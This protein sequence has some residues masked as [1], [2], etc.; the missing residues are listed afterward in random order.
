MDRLLARL[1]AFAPEAQF[2]LDYANVRSMLEQ[3]WPS[4]SRKD[5]LGFKRSGFGRKDLSSVFTTSNSLQLLKYSRLRRHL[6]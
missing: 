3:S 5:G 4:E 1:R 2:V 6:V